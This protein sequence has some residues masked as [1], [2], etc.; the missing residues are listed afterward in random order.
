MLLSLKRKWLLVIL[1]LLIVPLLFSFPARA[2][3]ASTAEA[4][5]LME[6][7]SGNILY[8]K[9]ATVAKAPASITKLMTLLLA[10]EAV[11]EGR[12]NWDTP[13]TVSEKAWRM[14]G[15]Q[16][17]LEVGDE[18]SFKELVTGISVVSANDAC[19]A[20][21]EHLTGSEAAF[22]EA[23]NTR[24][25]EI[26]LQQ[27]SF[28]N[29]TGLPAE[30][31]VMSCLD[32]AVLSRYLIENF[33]Q[34]LEFESQREFTY[35]DIKQYNRNPLLGRYSGADGLKTGW[36]EEAGYCLSATAERD[37]MRL[38]AVILNTNS[39]KERLAAAEEILDYGFLNYQLHEAVA[40]GEIIQE[41]PVTNGRQLSV[42]VKAAA[43][44]EVPLKKTKLGDLERVVVVEEAKA[45]IA[46]G[47]TLGKLEIKLAGK[48]VGETELVAAEDVGK[49][50]IF[51]RLFRW[52]LGLIKIKP[53]A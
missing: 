7:T 49:A 21:A 34:I 38:I 16:M 41:V 5:V 19:V 11:E 44:V 14:G 45:P 17:F 33:P 32:I 1:N 31:H 46:E 50:N 35:N 37:G 53:A 22:V 18:V 26:G 42:P 15:S 30:G 27:S 4:A 3:F 13:V 36:T 28:K 9:N 6:F 8:E 20:V 43:K 40:A 23:M 39:E 52:L 2:E 24:A 10:Y 51:V 29:A 48:V 47:E 25:R 12:V